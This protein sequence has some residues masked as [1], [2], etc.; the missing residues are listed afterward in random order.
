MPENVIDGTNLKWI[1][2]VYDRGWVRDISKCIQMPSIEQ[3]NGTD[4]S[5][6]YD[7]CMSDSFDQ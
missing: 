7:V 2:S 4:L 5:I 1:H 6:T 3:L